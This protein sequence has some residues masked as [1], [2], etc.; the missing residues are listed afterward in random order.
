MNMSIGQDRQRHKRNEHR[1][2]HPGAA[3]VAAGRPDQSAA[4]RAVY[5]GQHR[6]GA[7]HGS[8]G[9]WHAVDRLGRIEAANAISKAAVSS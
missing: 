6:I 7:Y 2:P 5:D 4:A 3:R 9:A 1:A 8:S